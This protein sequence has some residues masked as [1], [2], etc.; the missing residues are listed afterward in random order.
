MT[1]TRAT[2][3]AVSHT[4]WEP[5]IGEP[6]TKYDGNRLLDKLVRTDRLVCGRHYHRLGQVVKG[7]K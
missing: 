2:I 6:A 3:T 5:L 7:I 4:S 1:R